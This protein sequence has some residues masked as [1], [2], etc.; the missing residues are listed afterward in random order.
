MSSQAVMKFDFFGVLNGWVDTGVWANMSGQERA[1]SVA[2]LRH[3]GR[4]GLAWPGDDLLAKE[5]GMNSRNARKTRVRLVRRG[6]L[7]VSQA[8]GGRG[9]I[10][11]YR[12]ECPKTRS[13]DDPLSPPINPVLSEPE[14]RSQGDTKPGPK[15]TLNPVTVGPPNNTGRTNEQPNNNQADFVGVGLASHPVVTTGGDDDE[16]VVYLKSIG[17]SI[18]AKLREGL[19][20][21]QGRSGNDPIT[22]DEVKVL[23][24]WV[25]ANRPQKHRVGFMAKIIYDVDREKIIE[26][27]RPVREQSESREP[28]TGYG[29]GDDKPNDAPSAECDAVLLGISI[30]EA[31]AQIDEE[32][33]KLAL[34]A[35]MT[36]DEAEK[37]KSAYRVKL[38]IRAH[39]RHLKRGFRERG[40]W[41]TQS[42]LTADEYR[43][44]FERFV[45][46]HAGADD[47][48]TMFGPSM[49]PE[50][51]EAISL[52]QTEKGGEMLAHLRRARA[53]SNFTPQ[54]IENSKLDPDVQELQ[55]Q[56][57]NKKKSL[58]IAGAST[59]GDALAPVYGTK[60][61]NDL[62]F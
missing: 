41:R 27:I 6:V 15:S 12:I 48:N 49:L 28:R 14:T 55:K 22:L 1:L 54:E 25:I 60:E 19:S 17:I 51:E 2:Y 30:A 56:I 34:W 16:R 3:A 37:D 59:I 40:D 10:N 9:H 62:P 53:S 47:L 36:P 44:V 11:R 5:T 39:H 32:R 31:Q 43:E 58:G 24:K 38:A 42:E 61:W 57:E 29:E 23:W 26:A 13:Q 7:V 45:A 20:Q 8:G 4:D 33:E 50:F 46:D 18:N 21:L 35:T 52:K